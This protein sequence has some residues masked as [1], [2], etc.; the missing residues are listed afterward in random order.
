MDVPSGRYLGFL[1]RAGLS[2]EDPCV[3]HVS[4]IWN[5]LFFSHRHCQ[6]NP[7]QPEMVASVNT[8]LNNAWGQYWGSSK[9]PLQNLTFYFM[10]KKTLWDYQNFSP[11]YDLQQETAVNS[12]ECSMV[13]FSSLIYNVITPSCWINTWPVRYFLSLIVFVYNGGA[14]KLLGDEEWLPHYKEHQTKWET[15]C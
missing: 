2:T 3:V 10:F 8:W 13:T 1:I 15:H 9:I 12:K 5:V 4:Y 6:Q 14:S 11:S 7:S